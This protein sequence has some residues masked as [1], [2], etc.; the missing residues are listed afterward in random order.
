MPH[1]YRHS[2]RHSHRAAAIFSNLLI[3]WDR[4]I[5]FHFESSVIPFVGKIAPYDTYEIWK[6]DDNLSADTSFAGFDD[7][8]IQ[9]VDQ[10]LD[11]D[12]DLAHDILCGL[13]LV[14]NY[15]KRKIFNHSR[16]LENL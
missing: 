7:L 11:D 12:G 6:R 2:C 9:R 10:S 1:R 13:L 3:P 15:D 5:S 4:G 14:L 16:T 8:K